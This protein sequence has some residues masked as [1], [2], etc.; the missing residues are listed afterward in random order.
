[1]GPFI[2]LFELVGGYKVEVAAADFGELDALWIEGFDVVA[3]SIYLR[4]ALSAI[5]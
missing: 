5:R 4:N 3:R 1:L 2:S